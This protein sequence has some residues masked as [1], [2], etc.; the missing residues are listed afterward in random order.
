M[1]NND[2]YT[3]PTQPIR[4]RAELRIRYRLSEEWHEWVKR[5][6]GSPRTGIRFTGTGKQSN[7]KRECSLS[8]KRKKMKNRLGN[9]TWAN[10]G[11]GNGI[12]TLLPP[13]QSSS[14]PFCVTQL[15]LHD[16][17]RARTGLPPLRTLSEII[18]LCQPTDR[19]SLLISTSRICLVTG[20]T[21]VLYKPR[22]FHT[23]DLLFPRHSRC[24]LSE[25]PGYRDTM[26]F[27][28]NRLS[29]KLKFSIIDDPHTT[30]TS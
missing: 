5:K 22:Y 12:S 1:Y 13:L 20:P 23:L 4:L 28:H 29:R 19:V 16:R 21:L 6:L 2:C 27:K 17:D 9:A 8:K 10:F 25:K 15:A 30:S 14:G 18:G 26:R 24:R 3:V 7:K 11:L